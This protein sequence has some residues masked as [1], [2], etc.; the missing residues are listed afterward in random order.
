VGSA[1]LALA[2]PV[3]GAAQTG[4]IEGRVTLGAAAPLRR[5][6]NRYPG[7]AAAAP[8][9]QSL[10][11]VVYLIGLV[12]GADGAPAAPVMAQRDTAFVPPV[13]AVRVGGSVSFP[14]GDPFFHNVFSYSSAQ[15]FDLGRY[16]Q[17]ESKSVAFPEP[18][19]IEVFCEVHEFMRGAILVAE[20]PFHALVGAD[21]TF[22]I[23][24]VPPG[25][26]TVAFWHPDHETIQRRVSVTAGGAA[27]VEVEL[28]R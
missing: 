21:G 14:N 11:A 15:R 19:I 2:A 20:N 25:E 26:H 10:P 1:V 13:V 22:R 24:G 9:I 27:R 18:G 6:A 28:R 23:S 7:G 12:E 8:E 3:E 16:P 17:G 5:T 4:V